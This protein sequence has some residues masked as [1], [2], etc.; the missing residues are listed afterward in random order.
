MEPDDRND[1]DPRLQDTEAP[2]P[3]GTAEPEEPGRLK[4]LKRWARHNAPGF[5]RFL[6]S[7]ERPNPMLRE[8]AIG[9]FVILIAVALLWGGTGQKFGDSPVVVIESGSMMHCDQGRSAVLSS[10][11]EGTFGRLGTIDPGD[12]VFV[13]DIDKRSDVLTFGSQARCDVTDYDQYSC[14]CKHDSYGACGDVIIY[15]PGGSK[16]AVPIIHRAMFWLDIHGNGTYSIL[17]C[18]LDHVP[19]SE[20]ANVCLYNMQARNLDNAHHLERLGPED[21]GFVTLGDNNA[22]ADLPNINGLPVRPDW[23]LGKARG[24]VP[25]VGLVKLWVSDLVN[26]CSGDPRIPCNF[27]NAP[28]DVKTMMVLT[29]G[30][31]VASPFLVEKV[32]KVRA[33]RRDED[34]EDGTSQ[35]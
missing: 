13:K 35:E 9:A 14:A 11:C 12:L 31:L 28:G 21:S 25:W 29:I 10:Q 22:G 33:A 27:D 20:L 4:G 18:G 26:G 3:P 15:R 34:A 8:L 17:E 6:V 7:D 5:H 2:A 16:T 24:E 1:Q 23:I 30:T 32:Q 19:L